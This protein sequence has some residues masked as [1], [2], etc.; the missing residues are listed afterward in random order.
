MNKSLLTLYL[1]RVKE[2]DNSYVDK[3]LAQLAERLLHVPT[4]SDPLESAGNVTVKIIRTKEAHRAVVPVFTSSDLLKSWA[5]KNNLPSYSIS[6][7]GADLSM[8]LSSDSWLVINPDSE[9]AFELQPFMVERLMRMNENPEPVVEMPAHAEVFE[10]NTPDMPTTIVEMPETQTNEVPEP[11]PEPS[12]KRKG[13][14]LSFL[15]SQS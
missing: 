8:A 1:Q 10:T 12:P 9:T 6:L 7:L 3:L 15:K 13:S 5:E 2:G 11:M 14:F 4:D